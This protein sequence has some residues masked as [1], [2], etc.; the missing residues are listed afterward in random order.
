M[1][2]YILLGIILTVIIIL[3]VFVNFSP[4]FGKKPTGE[5]LERI[6]RSTNYK[7]GKFNN[8]KKGIGDF[9]FSAYKKMITEMLKKRELATPPNRTLTKYKGDIDLVSPIND[10]VTQFTWLGHSTVFVQIDG[11]NLL[12][13]PM[14][15]DAFGPITF[16]A[17]SQR[18]TNSKVVAIHDLPKIDAVLITH[19]HYDH[20]D[21]SSIKQLIGKVDRYFVP[22]GVSAHLTSWGV[23]E[24]KITELDWW[25]EIQ[26]KGLTLAA[27]PAQHF[28]GRGLM[29]KFSTLWMSWVIKGKEHTIYF[30]GDSGYFD[31]FKQIGEKYGPFDLTMIECG[32]FSEM[33]PEL[34]I[35]PEQ[36]P[37]AHIDLKGKALMSIHW[38]AFLLSPSHDWNEP[39]ER[40][41][42]KADEMKIQLTTPMIGQMV[43][44]GN[45]YPHSKWWR[46]E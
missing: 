6:E 39:I 14:L 38:G 40:L 24:E 31:G 1:I 29:D 21:L 3:A 5:I 41:T 12:I 33:W 37:Q 28:S 8:T 20:L 42:K 46:S 10:S 2:L 11:H 9:P 16:R 30:S 45:E 44:L 7:N 13:D 32:Q 25:E 26:F 23:D 35:F 34:H 15:G 4:Q 43:T 27:T 22:L 19:D 17:Q 18:F 36:I